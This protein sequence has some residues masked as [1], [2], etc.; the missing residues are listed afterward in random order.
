[1]KQFAWFLP[2]GAAETKEWLDK[3]KNSFEGNQCE[4]YHVNK[5]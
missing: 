5:A 4:K 1:M 3:L 2:D